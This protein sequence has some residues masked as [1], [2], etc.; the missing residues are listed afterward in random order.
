MGD[1]PGTQGLHPVLYY[2]APAGLSSCKEVTHTGLCQTVCCELSTHSH[3]LQQ[4]VGV[5]PVAHE[6]ENV[7]YIHTD[8]ARQ[9]AV[10]EDVC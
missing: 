9:G 6:V 8:A 3:L 1:V 2:V 4:A 10:E 7:A 5:C